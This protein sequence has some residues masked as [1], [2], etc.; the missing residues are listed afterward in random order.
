MCV[1]LQRLCCVAAQRPHPLKLRFAFPTARRYSS[2]IPLP[3]VSMQG[4]H[5]RTMHLLARRWG[6]D[7][8]WHCRQAWLARSASSCNGRTRGRHLRSLVRAI[9]ALPIGPRCRVTRTRRLDL[10]VQVA[11][12]VPGAHH[13]SACR[14]CA[15]RPT[16]SV[17]IGAVLTSTCG[18]P[19]EIRQRY[20]LL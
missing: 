15:C 6:F 1:C 7:I 12:L 16:G 9:G 13:A 17:A 19:F 3:C 14:R 4:R 18:T 11:T 20:Q 8:V 2:C 5:S 10:N